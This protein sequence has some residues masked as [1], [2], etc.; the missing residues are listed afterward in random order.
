MSRVFCQ[1]S[2]CELIANYLC[3]CLCVKSRLKPSEETKIDY[4]KVAP[5]NMA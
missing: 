1:M 5:S 4:Q 2:L 3:C